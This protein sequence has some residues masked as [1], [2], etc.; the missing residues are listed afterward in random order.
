[1]ADFSGFLNQKLQEAKSDIKDVSFARS[2]D[3]EVVGKCPYCKKGDLI[4][5]QGT[6]KAETDKRSHKYYAIKCSAKYGLTLR[7]DDRDLDRL[8]T[9]C[10]RKQL[11][12]L[13]LKDG[14][15]ATSLSKQGK[16]YPGEF[17]LTKKENGYYKINCVPHG[18]ARSHPG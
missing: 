14:F 1:M 13:V 3:N 12:D 7:T 11:I 4:V 18:K 5:F 9:K 2:N 8:K 16:E 17:Y 10:T 6:A 15:V